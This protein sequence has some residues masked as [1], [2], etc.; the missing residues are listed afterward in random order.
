MRFYYSLRYKVVDSILQK[1]LWM[2]CDA[3]QI[4]NQFMLLNTGTLL[5]SGALLEEEFM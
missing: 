5:A 4:D 2:C 3:V 1:I